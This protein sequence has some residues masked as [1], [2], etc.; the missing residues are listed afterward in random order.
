MAALRPDV[1][2]LEGVR[3]AYGGR[4]AVEIDR[5]QVRAGEVLV[6]MG[7][8]G[9]GKSSLLRVMGLLQ[10]PAAGRVWFKGRPVAAGDVLTAR[11]QM[12]S[13]F[14]D[15]LLVDGTVAANVALGLRF[16]GIPSAETA[17]RVR[18][19]LERLE[20]VHLAER[21]AHTISGGEA[22]RTALAR[23][24]VLQPDL[25]LLDEPFAALDQPSREALVAKL[26]GILRRDRITTVLITH[27]RGEAMT[28]ADRVGAMM[29]GRIQQLDEAAR[30][31]RA[32]V[33]EAVARFVGVETIVDVTVLASAAGLLT[34]DA[35]GQKIE[36]AGEG[37]AGD[38][39]RLCIRPEDVS[40][41]RWGARGAPRYPEAAAADDSDDRN[42]LAGTVSHIVSLGAHMRVAVDCGF[43]LMALVSRRTAETLGL[44]AG[45]PVVVSFAAPAAQLVPRG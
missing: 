18:A 39:V 8:N 23:A 37:L 35:S 9:S 4:V 29:D 6:L 14:Q 24:L 40:L 17:G 10:T 45:A 7:P 44:A 13:V 41:L 28:L 3:I 33:S 42:R 15:P 19:W 25:L 36:V 21:R 12:A 32:P 43:P 5:L 1:L 26:G 22:Q 20:I 16:R 2:D 27:D 34:L 38:R 31:F 11:R 30:V